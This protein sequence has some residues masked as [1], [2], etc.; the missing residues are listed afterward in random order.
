M[1][2]PDRVIGVSIM[3]CCHSAVDPET[4]TLQSLPHALAYSAVAALLKMFLCGLQ[5]YDDEDWAELARRAEAA[6]AHILELNFSCPQMAKEGSG[7]KV[8]PAG[9]IIVSRCSDAL[10]PQEKRESRGC[11]YLEAP[12]PP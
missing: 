12:V 6:G 7:H 4:I 3:V 10:F 11:L 8:P 2:Y 1:N 5:G 9:G